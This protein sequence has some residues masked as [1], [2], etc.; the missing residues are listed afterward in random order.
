MLVEHLNDTTTYLQLEGD[1]TEDICKQIQRIL[2]RLKVFSPCSHEEADTHM[3]LHAHLDGHPKI[4]I[5]TVDTDVMN[6]LHK[7]RL[8][9]PYMLQYHP[10]VVCMY[11]GI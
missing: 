6:M 5:H 3:L 8:E 11:I 1:P 7:C 2:H 4:L 10:G 9:L